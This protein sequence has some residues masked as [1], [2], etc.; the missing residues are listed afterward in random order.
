MRS[1]PCPLDSTTEPG[2]WWNQH[3]LQWIPVEAQLF[4]LFRQRSDESRILPEV[5]AQQLRQEYGKRVEEATLLDFGASEGGLLSGQLEQLFGRYRAVPLDGERASEELLLN[6]P[7]L[8][9]LHAFDV[10]TAIHTVQYM[11]RPDRVFAQ[12]AQY[13]KPDTIAVVVMLAT[14]GD[15]HHAWEL[16]LECDPTYRRRYDQ[17]GVFHAWLAANNVRFRSVVVWSATTVED[18]DTLRQVLTFFLGADGELVNDVAERFNGRPRLTTAHRVFMFPLLAQA[19]RP[20]ESLS[21]GQ[22]VTVHMRT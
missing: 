8:P 13:A 22:A 16:A 17:A 11:A 14:E 9:E 12:L 3:R 4:E 15:Q 10:L 7:H 5:I 20:L 1:W 6:L 21:S 19:G 18:Q 2:R